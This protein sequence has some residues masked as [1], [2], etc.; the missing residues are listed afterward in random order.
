MQV[1]AIICASN[2]ALMRGSGLCGAIFK[3]AGFELDKEC[4]SIGNCNT[5]D[6]VNKRL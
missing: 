4:A 1:D 5:G 2:N 3:K 6:A